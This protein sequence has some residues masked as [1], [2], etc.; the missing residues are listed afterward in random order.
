MKNILAAIL[1]IFLSSCAIQNA[2]TQNNTPTSV[3]SGS[4]EKEMLNLVNSYRTKGYKNHPP[5][6]PVKWNAKLEAAAKTH[7]N[8]MSANNV[9][10]HRG[11]NGSDPGKRISVTGYKWSTF[12]ENVAMGQLTPQEVMNTWMKSTSHRRNIMNKNVKEMGVA[13]TGRFWTQVFASQ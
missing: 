13:K 8:Y 5:V 4:F 12:S 1:M 7:S 6:P 10:G 11:K 2:P 3:R 9:L